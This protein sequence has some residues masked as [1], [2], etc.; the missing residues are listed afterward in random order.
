ML[1]LY[2][3]PRTRATLVQWYLDLSAYPAIV[4]YVQRLSQ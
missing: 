2:G 4:D 3:G 1:K